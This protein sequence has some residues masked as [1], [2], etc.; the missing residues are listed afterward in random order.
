MQ[1][2][3]ADGSVVTAS[4]S[5]NSDLFWALRGAGSSYGI[6]T[7]F[8]LQTKAAPTTATYYQINYAAPSIDTQTKVILAMQEFGATKAPAELALRIF[9]NNGTFQVYGVYWGSRSKWAR[10]IAPLVTLLPTTGRTFTVPGEEM[11][12][13][14]I[15]VRLNNGG[16]LEQPLNYDMHE[17]FFAK[18]IVT[19]ESDHLKPS[20]VTNFFTYLAT[21]GQQAP[22]NWW[23]IYDLYGGLGSQI[24]VPA[25]SA[26]AYAHRDSLFTIQIYS[27]APG[28]LPPYP[29][30]G[31]PFMEGIVD[32]ITDYQNQTTFKAYANY[33][34]PTLTKEQAWDLYYGQ[35]QMVKLNKVKDQVDPSRVFWNP[36]AIRA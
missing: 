32:S 28:Q 5:Q 12:W 20:T 9:L 29:Q 18:S 26:T 33:I 6:V 22:V 30:G 3:L 16:Q 2:V 10:A 7:Y 14:P 36:Q 31:Y 4:E 13:L 34:D 1:V 17:T 24:S 27:T 21:A 15:L 23:V 35:A 11:E 19:P 8:K 25:I